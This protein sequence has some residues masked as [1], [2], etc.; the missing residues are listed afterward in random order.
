MNYWLQRLGMAVL[1]LLAVSMLTFGAMNVLGD[2]LFNVLGPVAN[3][4]ELEGTAQV[5]GYAIRTQGDLPTGG[6]VIVGETPELGIG[7]AV[8]VGSGD[9]LP[10]RADTVVASDVVEVD[11]ETLRVT[12]AIVPG[13]GVLNG[14][15]PS[16]LADVAEAE[17]EFYL[18][19]PL[20]LRYAR[21]LG[22]F[23]T[24]DLGPQFSKT[25]EP[26][27]SD[28][29][30]ERLPRTLMLLVMAQI[31]ATV[32][33]IPWALWAAARANSSLDRTSTV[34][35]F[36]IVAL[37]NFALGVILKWLFAIKLSWFPQTFN[38]SDPFFTRMWQ[39]FL[40]ALTI[41][42]P[43]AAVYQR[44]L[45]TDLITTLPEDF[46]L[47][48]RSKGVS[49]RDVLYKHALR[50]S[51]FSFITVFGINTG[52]LI[53]GALVVENIFRVPG[54]GSAIVEAVLVEDFPVV[55]AI[56]MIVAVA[57]VAVN[58]VIDLV[59]TLID[60]RVRK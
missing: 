16:Q 57:F 58:I 36:L 31:M 48:A 7:E 53:G 59:Y 1:L 44:L 17:E 14:P 3:V 34:A 27:V 47:M 2:P 15:E 9:T 56:V 21:W 45:R 18:D 39:M 4:T 29:I 13:Q 49:R 52:A 40:P 8:E 5:D 42:L 28:L 33:A 55:L 60:P 26:P 35:T 38:A 10:R 50:S 51:L 6:L 20:P 32:I 41:A 22:D 54:L 12:G 24:G 19:D 46:I 23:A 43:A 30:K 11:G 25:G 37:P